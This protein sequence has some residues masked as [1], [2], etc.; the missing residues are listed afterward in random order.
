LEQRE[1]DLKRELPRKAL[2]R[3]TSK[4]DPDGLALMMTTGKGRLCGSSC[5]FHF[6]RA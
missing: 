6:L 4:E 3:L 1:K 5:L 2:K